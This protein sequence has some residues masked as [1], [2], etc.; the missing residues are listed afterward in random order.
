LWFYK[1]AISQ[2]ALQTKI[3]ICGALLNALIS[4]ISLK[5]WMHQHLEDRI[6]CFCLFY[7]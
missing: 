4:D 3:S 2:T 1:V 6:I 7:F 5:L